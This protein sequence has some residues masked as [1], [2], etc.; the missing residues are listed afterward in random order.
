MTSIKTHLNKVRAKAHDTQRKN[1]H[2]FKMAAASAKARIDKKK[3][4]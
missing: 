3:K 2:Y 4:I 1:G